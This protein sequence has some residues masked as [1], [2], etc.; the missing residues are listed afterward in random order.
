VVTSKF[1]LSIVIVDRPLLPSQ[2]PDRSTVAAF[3]SMCKVPAI[4]I[5]FAAASDVWKE[6]HSCP[7]V[8][9]FDVVWAV[10]CVCAR[11]AG[12]SWTR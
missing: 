2:V 8:G 3:L 4:R 9:S 7:T 5:D 10:A 11:R 12:S 1:W 6:F